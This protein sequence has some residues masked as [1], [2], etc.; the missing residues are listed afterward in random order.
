MTSAT[1]PQSSTTI[2]VYETTLQT[3]NRKERESRGKPDHWVNSKGTSFTNPWPSWVPDSWDVIGFMVDLYAN[4]PSIPKDVDTRL[5]IRKPTWGLESNS[6]NSAK[7]KATWLGHACYLVELPSVSPA[8]R[9]ARILFD[10]V[11][12]DRCSPSQHMGPKRYTPPPC[13]V[14]DIPEVDAIVI[15]HNHYD[16]LDT[17]TITT[18]FKRDRI[19]HIFAPLGNQPYFDKLHIPKTHAHILDWWDSRR[20]EVNI[21]DSNAKDDAQKAVFDVT[22]TPGQHRTGRGILDHFKSLWAGWVV[23]EVKEPEAGGQEGGGGAKVYFAGDTGYRTVLKGQDED[24]V[25]VCPA[26]KEIGQRWGGIDLALLPIGAYL[27][28]PMMSRVHCTPSDA[29]RVFQDIR[30]KRALAMHWGTWVLTNEPVFEPPKL[31]V[32]ECRKAGIEDGI[33]A[34]CDIGQ[35][36]FF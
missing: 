6:E 27:P 29:V 15:S 2:R 10:P 11:F 5:P 25:P 26:F 4:P 35:T 16:H 13:A 12:S 23:E 32:E 36:S 21:Q 18:L 31:L 33:F 7:I 8:S 24:K 28:R 3:Q 30:A 34:I 22:C 1:H 20:V 19:P 14:E 9:G 17:P